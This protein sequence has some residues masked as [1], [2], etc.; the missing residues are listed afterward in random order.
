MSKQYRIVMSAAVVAMG[1]LVAGRT[2]A[3]SLDPTNAPGPTMHTLEEIYQRVCLIP[4][5]AAGSNT[6]SAPVPKTGQTTSY[7]TGDDGYYRKGLA[8]PSPRFTVQAD[9]NCVLDNLTGLVWARNANMGGAR[10][11]S[12]AIVY[13][14]ALNYGGQTDW[15]LPNVRELYS[16][17]DLSPYPTLPSGHP[18]AGVQTGSYW[19]SSTYGPNPIL[20]WYV[21][22]G[23]GGVYNSDKGNSWYVWPVRGGQ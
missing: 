22:T 17:I 7:Q 11:W 6:N 9:T 1:L 5:N 19:S 21:D 3:G 4:T 18:F 15:R 16:L 23:G 13:C 20:A 10:T 2:L 14:E 8:S 12:N